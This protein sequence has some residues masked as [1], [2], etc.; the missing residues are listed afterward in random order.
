M[1]IFCNLIFSLCLFSVL[2]SG[3]SAISKSGILFI[4]GGGTLNLFALS[5]DFVI[6]FHTSIPLS[7]TSNPLSISW[8]V[9]PSSSS[10]S[11][12]WSYS[13]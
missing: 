4:G 7:R 12:S 13:F 6:L 3:C 9:K 10:G 1:A 2:T 11:K 8:R 5:S